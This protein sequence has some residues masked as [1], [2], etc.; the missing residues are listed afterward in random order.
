MSRGLEFLANYTL[1]RDTDGGEVP[2][3][4]GTY[5]GTDYPIDPMNRRVEYAASDLNQKH[6]FVGS[7]VWMPRLSGLSSAPARLLVNGWNF[8]TIVTL[9]SGQPVT[10]YLSGFPTGGADGGLTGGTVS[11]SGGPTSGRAPWIERNAYTMPAIHNMDFRIG[12]EFG[13]TERMK[14]QFIGEAF[15][16]FNTTN[17][18]CVNTTAFNYTKPG[19]P[20]CVGHTN[21]C[22]VPNAAFLRPTQAST[23][24]YTSRQ[25]QV[26]ARL[27]F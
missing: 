23:F 3:Q 20:G 2:G 10:P 12:R 11:N 15:N 19:A 17:I 7:A 13:V 5:F 27:T 8:S 16:L 14:L 1:S 4:Y 22:L 6:R 25:L 24:I 26:S 18:T 9:G 21:A